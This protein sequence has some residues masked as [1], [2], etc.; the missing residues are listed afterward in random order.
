M[1]TLLAAVLVVPL[2]APAALGESPVEPPENPAAK[3]WWANRQPLD[4]PRAARV[5]R[6]DP[7]YMLGVLVYQR[8]SVEFDETPLRDVIAHL[9]NAL[10]INLMAR[11]D[12]RDRLTTALDGETPITLQVTD[13]PALEVLE[14]ILEQCD[15]T[16]QEGCTWQLRRGFIEVGTKAWLSRSAAQEIRYYPI[17]DLMH[18]APWLDNAPGFNLSAAL[19]QTGGGG[20]GVGGGQ[21]GGG[22]GGG[23]FGG[24]GR[25]RGSGPG[26]GGGVIDPPGPERPRPDERQLAEEI[27]DMI[28]ES[29]E[30]YAWPDEGGSY[31]TL[32]YTNGVLIV[33]APD[34][35]HRQIN[36]YRFAIRPVVA[37][38]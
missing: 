15:D 26:G 14:M 25:G 32:R 6:S 7:E 28:Q 13:R 37:V 31:A 2:A 16:L 34:Y 35:I 27:A 29:I 38:D 4:A 24:G 33:R 22:L 23:G 1:R 36:G 21:G 9:R 11:Y 20:G 12:D 30:P 19:N 8:I 18:A 3:W 17:R 5:E 10:G